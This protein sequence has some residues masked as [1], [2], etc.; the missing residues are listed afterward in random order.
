MHMSVVVAAA[1]A[2]ADSTSL[3]LIIFDCISANSMPPDQ[4]RPPNSV[5]PSR[6]KL[7]R[8]EVIRFANRT[9]VR[10]V[11]RI[12]QNSRQPELRLLWVCAVIGAAVITLY[13]LAAVIGKYI[14]FEAKV[15]IYQ[16][17]DNPEF[18][19]V[20]VC[21]INPYSHPW[22][23]PREPTIDEYFD[24]VGQLEADITAGGGTGAKWNQ[25]SN[26]VGNK[27]D[28]F[29]FLNSPSGYFSNMVLSPV[30][31]DVEQST[32]VVQLDYYT[33]NLDAYN[34]QRFAINATVSLTFNPSYQVCYLFR[35]PAEDA[36]KVRA[37]S[38]ILYLYDFPQ[39]SIGT[40]DP[41]LRVS[42]S[43]GVSVMLHARGTFPD[44]MLGVNVAPGSETTI[45]MKASVTRRLGKP[46]DNCQSVA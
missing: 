13:Q 1:A 37:I 18:P 44:P 33:W 22:H 41:N 45:S 26:F 39:G 2:A 12:V 4:Q 6:V 32:M 27:N 38:G 19:D 20:T 35:V 16:A 10:G 24:F 23:D 15:V 31:L 42:E 11:S 40:F 9:T 21:K 8:D 30:E 7:I 28:V 29:V 34:S 43:S 17:D 14:Q 36:T 46:Y 3:D 25:S 5:P